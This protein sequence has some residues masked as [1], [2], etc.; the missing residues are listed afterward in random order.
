MV[1]VLLKELYVEHAGVRRSMRSCDYGNYVA[2]VFTN[3][4][5]GLWFRRGRRRLVVSFILYSKNNYAGL[6]KNRT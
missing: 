5:P 2:F 4:G 6:T 3:V 1:C